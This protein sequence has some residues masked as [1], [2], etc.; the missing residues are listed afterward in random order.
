[1]TLASRRHPVT[2]HE[3]GLTNPWATTR[4]LTVT[5]SLGAIKVLALLSTAKSSPPKA[6]SDS[7]NF[8]HEQTPCSS[9]VCFILCYPSTAV[10][11][12]QQYYQQLRWHLRPGSCW[13]PGT[14]ESVWAFKSRASLVS[15]GDSPLGNATVSFLKS[16][17]TDHHIEQQFQSATNGSMHTCATID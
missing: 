7:P 15:L 2:R 6:S 12:S 17:S 16:T 4:V 11:R 13:C 5:N 8:N 3:P 14:C 10:D 1:V 9:W